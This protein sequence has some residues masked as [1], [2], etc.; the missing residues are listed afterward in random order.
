MFFILQI[1]AMLAVPVKA[2][3]SISVLS[4]VYVKIIFQVVNLTQS[5]IVIG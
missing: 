5:W 1:E 2:I 4:S 3:S